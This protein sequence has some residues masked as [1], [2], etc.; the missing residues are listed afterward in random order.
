MTRLRELGK[1]AQ[2]SRTVDGRISIPSVSSQLIWS[3]TMD[4]T[5]NPRHF[6]CCI[7]RLREVMACTG[8]R[9]ST[10]YALISEGRFPAQVH[11]SARMVGWVESEIEGWIAERVAGRA[12]NGAAR[13]AP[14]KSVT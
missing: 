6:H 3:T 7:L 10:L 5:A 11:L 12:A 8:L 1:R 2:H 9:R 4:A 14:A 13:Q